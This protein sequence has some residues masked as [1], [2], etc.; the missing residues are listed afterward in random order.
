MKKGCIRLPLWLLLLIV[1]VII[2]GIITWRQL[3]RRFHPPSTN[4]ITGN[5]VIEATEVDL[6]SKVAGRILALFTDE[7]QE[8]KPGQLI[9]ILDREEQ[10]GQLRAAK[11]NTTAVK[12]DL[13]ALKAGSRPQELQSAQAQYDA[14]VS[15]LRQA[16]ARRDLVVAGSRPEDIAQGRA[17]LR[18]VQA[19]LSLVLA[20]PRKEEIAQLRAQY[21]Q[22]LANLSLVRAGPRKEVIAQL[23]A[24]YAQALANLSLVLAGPRQ[25]DR[26]GGGRTQPGAGNGLQC[27]N[28]T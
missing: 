2:V 16:Q 20:G 6:S 3:Q 12:Q 25:E 9:A 28:R 18:Q 8:I 27:G 10:R 15:N 21:A 19:N 14:A 13:A 11:G 24:Q 17:A 22:A 1:G 23:R 7:G 5:G 26:P 4:T